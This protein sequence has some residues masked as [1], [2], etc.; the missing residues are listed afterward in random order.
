MVRTFYYSVAL[1]LAN[2]F[3]DQHNILILA[4]AADDTTCSQQQLEE[5]PLTDR[6]TYLFE[7]LK[8]ANEE[9][10]RQVKIRARQ[11]SGSCSDRAGLQ[12]LTGEQQMLRVGSYNL[13][14][15]NSNWPL[16]QQGIQSMLRYLNTDIIAVQEI[17]WLEGQSWPS[18]N[19]DDITEETAEEAEK[20]SQITEQADSGTTDDDSKTCEEDYFVKEN[21]CHK[22]PTFEHRAAGDDPKGEDTQCEV[23]YKDNGDDPRLDAREAQIVSLASGAGYEFY[24]FRSAAAAARAVNANWTAPGGFDEEAV[25]LLSK[26]PILDIQELPLPPPWDAPDRNPRVILAPLVNVS[27]VGMVRVFSSHLSYERMEQC[28][29]IPLVKQFAD[30]LWHQDRENQEGKVVPQLLMGDLNIYFDFEWPTDYLT[31]PK[32]H[33]SRSPVNPCAAQFKEV[34]ANDLDTPSFIDAWEMVKS[35]SDRGYSFP[36]PE[37]SSSLPP[38]RCDRIL[39]RGFDELEETP[40][41]PHR[42]AVLGCEP[43]GM[44]GTYM[45][46]HRFVVSDFFA[47]AK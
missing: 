8:A 4:D 7:K 22:C 45:S 19:N 27:G 15:L 38:A 12:Q 14:N 30:K 47:K 32:G 25:G 31:N 9:V 34:H 29:T 35:P 21:R 23:K 36:N 46:D 1:L 20:N 2:F 24:T 17:R 37:T 10:R 42:A 40:L 18:G 5:G 41:K 3:I 6:E 11:I 26:H 43:L 33:L 28:R 44:S 16:R 39:S 13:W